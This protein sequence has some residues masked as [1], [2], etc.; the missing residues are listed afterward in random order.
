MYL[1]GSEAANVLGDLS[2]LVGG[3]VQLHHAGPC[4]KVQ[5]QRRQL[6][7]L[8]KDTKRKEKKVARYVSKN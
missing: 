1:E 4:P 8:I 6:V 3:Q 2:Q 7:V 5:R